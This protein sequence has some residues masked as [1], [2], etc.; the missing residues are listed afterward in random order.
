MNK[1]LAIFHGAV[2]RRMSEQLTDVMHDVENNSMIS[3]STRQKTLS[4]MMQQKNALVFG[5]EEIERAY[6]KAAPVIQGKATESGTA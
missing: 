6:G 5:A 2:L 4:D 1:D 3:G